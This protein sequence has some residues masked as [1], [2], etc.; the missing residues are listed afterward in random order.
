[1]KIYQ[2]KSTEQKEYLISPLIKIQMFLILS[3]EIIL[4]FLSISIFPFPLNIEH[5]YPLALSKIIENNI[6]KHY[7]TF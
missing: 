7:Y 4:S 5:N 3:N 2:S 1:M 6:P